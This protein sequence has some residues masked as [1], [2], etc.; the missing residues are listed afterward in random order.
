MGS[1]IEEFAQRTWLDFD[2]PCVRRTIVFNIS[3]RMVEQNQARIV[4]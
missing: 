1:F 3:H 4:T 2:I